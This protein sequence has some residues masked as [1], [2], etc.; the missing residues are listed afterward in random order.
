MNAKEQIEILKRGTVDF[1]GEEDLLKRLSSGKPL[2][3]KWG[4][5]PSAP[6]LHLGH[7]VVLRKLRAFQDLGHMVVFLI[8]DFTGMIGD[9]SGKNETRKPLSEEVV[10][11]N[12]KTYQEQVFRIL[13][14]S[15]TEVVYNSK[16]LS[17]M[18]LP[19]VMKLMS[20][21]SVARMLERGD[22]K[23]RFK[24]NREISMVEFLY[25]LMQGYD[26]VEIKAD[27]ELGGHDQIFNLLVGRELQKAY[28]QGPQVVITMPLLEGTDGKMKM[29]KSL[30]NYIGF[31][32]SPKEIFG[33]T[34]SIPDE[35][36]LK[37]YELLT[38][39]SA[40][41]INGIK[42]GLK[43]GSLHPKEVKKGLGK[44]F[45]RHFYDHKAADAAEAEFESVFGQNKL[46]EDMPVFKL[47]TSDLEGGS[48]SVTK[49]I[50][51]SGL[52]ESGGEA[53]RM[54]KGGGVKLNEEKVTD[55]AVKISPKGEL[56]LSVGKRK[57]VK[58][59]CE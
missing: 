18:G 16:W 45:V 53:K 21:Y 15:R 1:V 51:M 8:G 46:P 34:M 4:A 20:Q 39:T 29:S 10:K 19:E 26:S 36:M 49:L 17:K 27:V 44:I 35:M 40:A 22:F 47:K 41:G 12:A 14:K 43:N 24:E 54:I 11:K 52:L 48:I 42:E 38:D 2:R 30:N 3:V 28:G 55:E 32:E 5:D 25:P 33:K 6:D 31:T 56:I 13:D 7:M 59:I 37:Y 50:V 58:V 9:P 23:E 57:F